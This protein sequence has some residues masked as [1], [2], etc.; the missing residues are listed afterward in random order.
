VGLIDFLRAPEKHTEYLID[1]ATKCVDL[2]RLPGA[3]VPA[4]QGASDRG[5]RIEEY[6]AKI[7]DKGLVAIADDTRSD[8][9]SVEDQKP[10][11]PVRVKPPCPF[12]HNRQRLTEEVVI[13]RMAKLL[14]DEVTVPF[15]LTAEVCMQAQYQILH[16]NLDQYRVDDLSSTS[17]N[18]VIEELRPTQPVEG[19]FDITNS[20]A[21]W[22]LR[23]MLALRQKPAWMY[24]AIERIGAQSIQM[25][26]QAS[27]DGWK[28]RN[29]GRE[30]A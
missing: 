21:G 27:Y 18:G 23:I 11:L 8:P 7:Q 25:A 9:T 19:L 20:N 1:F 22:L 29:I 15:T 4:W 28:A 13:D 12:T 24:G 14:F 5:D 10:T 16:G 17:L 26:R 30:P 6:R 3:P 2:K